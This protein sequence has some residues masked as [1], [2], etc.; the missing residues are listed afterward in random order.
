M[1]TAFTEDVLSAAETRCS[2]DV[3][4]SSLIWEKEQS[5]TWR[6]EV[7]KSEIVSLVWN[8]LLRPDPGEDPVPVC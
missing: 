4:P 6:T 2:L 1:V 5:F 7:S 8:C 3:T